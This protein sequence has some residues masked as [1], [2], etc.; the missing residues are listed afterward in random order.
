MN[1]WPLKFATLVMLLPLGGCMAWRSVCLKPSEFVGRE[2]RTS[3]KYEIAKVEYG[4][5]RQLGCERIE[6]ALEDLFGSPEDIDRIMQYRPGVFAPR[7]VPVTVVV[8]N[9]S[10]TTSGQW[11]WV[12]PFALT[13]TI[14][15][16]FITDEYFGEFEIHVE[17]VGFRRVSYRGVDSWHLS[18]IGPLGYIPY[19]QPARPSAYIW[20]RNRG[21]VSLEPARQGIADAIA[22]ALMDMEKAHK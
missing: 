15:P 17:G 1:V 20:E 9:W 11:T 4:A 19:P 14:V 12:F 8:Q 18:C 3:R 22:A 2:A 13:A 6:R 5:N 21:K 7:G 16:A 10:R